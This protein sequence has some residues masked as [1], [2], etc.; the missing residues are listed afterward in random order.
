MNVG[1]QIVKCSLSLLHQKEWDQIHLV[2]TT[3]HQFNL[4]EN[5][6]TICSVYPFKTL[7]GGDHIQVWGTCKRAELA[8]DFEESK[9]INSEYGEI[10]LAFKPNCFLKEG[11]T[12]FDTN[13]FAFIKL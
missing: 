6:V 4:I 8:Q 3:T 1:L 5:H 11:E 10:E 2:S 12:I 13:I 7:Y 9:Q